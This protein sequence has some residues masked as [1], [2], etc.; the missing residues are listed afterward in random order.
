MLFNSYLFIFCFLPIVWAIFH[1]LKALSI[2]QN[3][4]VYMSLAKGFLVLASLF[5][6]AYWKLIYLPILLGSMLVNYGV[7]RGILRGRNGGGGGAKDSASG[8]HSGDFVDFRATADHKSSSTLKSTKSPT[9]TTANPRIFGKDSQKR[10]KNPTASDSTPP[11]SQNTVFSSKILESKS[12]TEAQITKTTQPLESSFLQSHDSKSNAYFLSSR[13]VLAARQSTQTK[14]QNLESTFENTAQKSKKVDSTKQAHFLS[15]RALLRKAWQSAAS[16]VIINKKVDSSFSTHNTPMQQTP[17]QK[18]DS[19]FEVMDCHATA[20]ALAR[21]DTENA[22]SK[23]ADSSTATTLNEQ[24]KDSRISIHNAQNVFDKKSQAEGFCD[25]KAGLCSGEQGDKTCGLSTQGA[26]NSLL[27][28]AKQAKR[29]FFRKQA[30]RCERELAGFFRKPTP[31]PN[32]AQSSKK[33]NHPKALLILGIIFNLCLLGIFKYTD[34][35][36]ENFNL[37]TKLLALDFAIP[38]PHILLPLALSFVT[39]QQIAFLVDCYKQATERA[40]SSNPT[41]EIPYTNF[42]DYCLF[43]TFFPQLIAGPIVHHKEMMPQF[44]AMGRR[45]LILGEHSACE[46]SP[47]LSLRADL[48]AR[49]SINKKADSRFSTHNAPMQQ[50]PKQN[51]DS[52]VDCHALPTDKARNDRNNATFG[53]VDSNLEAENVKN[54]AQDSRICDEK[55]LL[56]EPRKEIRL[57]C[58][59]TQRGDAIKDLSRKAESSKKTESL[60]MQKSTP[61]IINWEYIAKGLFIFSIGLFKKVVIADSF[62]KWANAGFSAVENGAV[63]N[64]L[65]SWA[66]SLSYTFELYFDFSG[67]CDMAI[68]LGLL[69]GIILPINFSSPYK[70][71]NIAE[72]WRKWHITLGRFLKEYLYIPLGGNQNI[73]RVSLTQNGDYSGDSTLISIQGKSLGS[74]CKA[75]FLAQRYCR[76]PAPQKKESWLNNLLT[77]R[78]LFIVAFLSGVWHGAGWGFVIWGSLHGLAMVGHRIYMLLYKKLDSRGVYARFMQSKAYILLCWLLTFNCVNIAWVFFRAENVQGAINLL[79]GMFGGEVV[80]L[81]LT[82]SG[83]VSTNSI[84]VW[85]WIFLAFIL[86]LACKN[87]IALST[88]ISRVGVIFAGVGCAICLLKIIGDR[89]ASSPFLYFNF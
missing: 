13:A 52:S 69:F 82:D 10:L 23:N 28:R 24:P 67:Y 11:N 35:F 59:S 4:S 61:S 26:T 8:S 43:I 37:F 84:E 54:T 85:G 70:A 64:C 49:Q 48:S 77:L 15:L 21:N 58:L 88:H 42:L 36:L 44:H 30:K 76:E 1:L 87:S 60:Q 39:F 31:K 18:V 50:T 72:F 81:R 45:A 47:F 75:P 80:W 66:T 40:E 83:T 53:K 17:K 41:Q 19:N 51:A 79:K 33:L 73:K 2:T 6:Y 56:C 27:F 3:S 20:T 14:T 9:S 34:F 63:L 5:F 89:G 7:V 32:Q 29:S 68:G 12:G 62:A 22:A 57:E 16:L 38:L 25:E 65:E 71:L 46:K 55:S 86:A 78:N 74:P